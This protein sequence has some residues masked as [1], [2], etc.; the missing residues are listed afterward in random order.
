ML[1]GGSRD[2]PKRQR[3]MRD[4]IAWS[5]DL[6][7]PHE[8]ALFRRLGVFAGGFTLAAADA[9]AVGDENL[10]IVDGVVALVEQSL[11]R[12][13]PG[14][15]DEP[16][17]EMLETVREFGLEQVTLAGELDDA[18]VRHAQHFFRFSERLVQ[19]FSFFSMDLEILSRLAPEQDN[20][21]L[22][23]A[24]F[25]DHDEIEGLLGLSSLLYGPWLARGQY[26]EGRYW[27]ERAL[28]RSSPAAS[29]ARVRALVAA[30]M[31]ATFQGDYI[32]ATALSA[33][34]VALAS[35][36]CDPLLVG[37]ALT[38]AGF[39]AYRQGAY[40]QAETLAGR[41]L[42]R[43]NQLG[44]DVSATLADAGFALLILGSTALVQE[45]FDRAAS[46]QEAALERFRRAGNDWGIGEAHN[47]LGAV[48]Y[49]TGDIAAAAA[50][51]LENLDRARII[52]HPLMVGSALYGLA[53]VAAACGQP[54]TG[55]R[56][57]GAAEGIV[58]SL[59]APMYPGDRLVRERALAALRVTLGPEQLA[60][61][62]EA[63]R[64]L[65]LEAASAEAEAVAAAVTSSPGTGTTCA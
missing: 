37:Q 39:L 3:T 56:L 6:L 22:A 51:Y 7:A 41:G 32:G 38:L 2:L 8:Q 52:R 11:I 25:D 59:G 30:G 17:Y 20:V 49:C 24:W 9:V 10:S 4:A 34:G 14:V 12:Q 61:G 55:A 31:L 60:A 27:L 35:E 58:S 1:S 28:E 16:R 40:G 46:Q 57:L 18:R 26:R 62:Q 36:L 19:G 45:Q 48:S 43:L 42:A 21:R 15:G 64:A 23:L 54:G 44:D 65:T 47:S 5:Y 33:E 63:G 13:I 50:H 53:G 29:A